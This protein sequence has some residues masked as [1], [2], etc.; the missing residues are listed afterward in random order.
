MACVAVE[1]LITLPG[2]NSFRETVPVNNPQAAK[3]ICE[4]KYPNATQ[5]VVVRQVNE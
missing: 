2:V 3:A 1:M 4:S 5:I